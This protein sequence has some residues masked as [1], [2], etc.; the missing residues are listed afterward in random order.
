MKYKLPEGFKISRIEESQKLQIYD[1][2]KQVWGNADCI[3]EVFEKIEDYLTALEKIQNIKIP[4]EYQIV[5]TNIDYVF[6]LVKS[7]GH[8]IMASN[9]FEH[10]LEEATKTDQSKNKTTELDLQIAALNNGEEIEL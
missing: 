7:N 1:S 10:I 3:K 9:S 6:F 2:L 8:V 5:C 4:N